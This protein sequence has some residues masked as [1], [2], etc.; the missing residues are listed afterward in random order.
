MRSDQLTADELAR[1]LVHVRRESAERPRVR[2]PRSLGFTDGPFDRWKPAERL[3]FSD[4]A[5]VYDSDL[6]A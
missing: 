3:G 2:W 1:L 6:Y 4:G 5:S